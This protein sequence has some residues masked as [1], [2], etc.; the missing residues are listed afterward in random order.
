MA[1]RPTLYIPQCKPQGARVGMNLFVPL[2]DRTQAETRIAG[3]QEANRK[4]TG[5]E[6]PNEHL[7]V[8]L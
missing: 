5:H 4:A 8:T 6:C 1:R 2:R 7:I 3:H